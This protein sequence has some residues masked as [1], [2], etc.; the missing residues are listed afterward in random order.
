MRLNGQ[1]LDAANL[2][3]ALLASDIVPH[4]YHMLCTLL[5]N[6]TKVANT[7]RIVNY[8]FTKVAFKFF[9]YKGLLLADSLVY[10]ESDE[11]FIYF[12]MKECI[13]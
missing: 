12:F 7:F 13:A 10:L 9:R 5:F 4:R 8:C 2:L 11:V 3:L 1:H 6:F